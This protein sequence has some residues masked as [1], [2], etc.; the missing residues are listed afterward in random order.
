MKDFIHRKK[1]KKKIVIGSNFCL[2]VIVTKGFICLNRFGA[3]GQ[4]NLFGEC[5]TVACPITKG[6]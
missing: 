6:M 3:F 4:V 1:K 5:L 2:E